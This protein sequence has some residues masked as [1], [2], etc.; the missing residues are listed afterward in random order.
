[1]MGAG[2]ECFLRLVS[3]ACRCVLLDVSRSYTNFLTEFDRTRASHLRQLSCDAT[4]SIL[5]E[6]L[7]HWSNTIL[8]F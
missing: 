4:G 8:D 2:L 5:D 7:L 3:F 6:E 1:M